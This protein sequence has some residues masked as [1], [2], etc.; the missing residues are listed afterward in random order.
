MQNVMWL[1]DA[2]NVGCGGLGIPPES[3][4]AMSTCRFREGKAYS[5]YAWTTGGF[6]LY[7]Y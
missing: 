4:A 6:G 1:H 5:Q 3:K 2:L 7:L